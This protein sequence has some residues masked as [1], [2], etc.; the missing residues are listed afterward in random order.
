[1]W[2]GGDTKHAYTGTRIPEL[3]RKKKTGE[4]EM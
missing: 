1:M 4:P 2:V 3:E